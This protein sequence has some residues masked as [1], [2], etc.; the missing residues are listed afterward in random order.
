MIHFFSSPS[1]VRLV[2]FSSPSPV[3]YAFIEIFFR[4]MKPGQGQAVGGLMVDSLC[5]YLAV[6]T[7]T[8]RNNS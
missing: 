3:V 4:T 5:L 8:R 7:L 6:A 1:P 2:L